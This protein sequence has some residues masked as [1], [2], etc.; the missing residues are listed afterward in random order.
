MLSSAFGL[1]I[2]VLGVLAGI[3]AL[4]SEELDKTKA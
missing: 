3:S 4:L 2:A 1:I